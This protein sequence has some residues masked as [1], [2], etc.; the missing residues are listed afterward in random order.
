MARRQHRRWERV[1]KTFRRRVAPCTARQA[2]ELF[3][4]QRVGRSG[5][6]S[7][8]VGQA[9]VDSTKSSRI[10]IAEIRHLNWGR[11][12]GEEKCE[13]CRY[14]LEPTAEVSYCWHPKLRILVGDS[15][16]CQWWEK[17]PEPS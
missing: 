13:N 6:I 7:D 14:Y 5:R 15:W 12:Q 16:W 10:R 8:R 4:V 11:P 17:E 9:I 1:G 3:S 2:N